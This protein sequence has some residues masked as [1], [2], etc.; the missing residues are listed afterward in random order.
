[1]NKEIKNRLNKLEEYVADE[2]NAIRKLIKESKVKNLFDITTY[3]QVC[4]ELKEKEETCP[5]E[6]I[7]QIEKL[8]NG[9]WK[10]NWL[11]KTQQKWYPYFEYE[12][13]GLV[14]VFSGYFFCVCLSALGQVGFYKDKQTSDHVGKHFIDIYKQIID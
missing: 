10:K 5:Y 6:K 7:K 12:T 11:D 4:E 8:F 1:M 2:M 9:A 14:F 3:K 13:S